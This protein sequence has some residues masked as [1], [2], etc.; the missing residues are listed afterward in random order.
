MPKS[1]A[2]LTSPVRLSPR[3]RD[4]LILFMRGLTNKL[5]ARELGIAHWTVKQYSKTLYRK[6]G[7][8]HRTAAVMWGAEQAALRLAAGRPTLTQVTASHRSD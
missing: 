6:L 4:V 1:P 5:V 8:H 2:H 3:E 7:V